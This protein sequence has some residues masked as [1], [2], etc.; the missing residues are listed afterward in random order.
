[1]ADVIPVHV[2]QIDQVL[3]EVFTPAEEAE[4][5]S[6]LRRLRDYTREQNAGGGCPG[7]DIAPPCPGV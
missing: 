3:E 2:A 4:F 7:E 6:M 1:M 5:G